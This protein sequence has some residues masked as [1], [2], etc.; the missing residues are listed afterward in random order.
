MSVALEE[1]AREVHMACVNGADQLRQTYI[2]A[3]KHYIEASDPPP[4]HR[5]ASQPLLSGVN[6]GKRWRRTWGNRALPQA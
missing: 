5:I 6:M 3:I 1:D 2:A 4:S